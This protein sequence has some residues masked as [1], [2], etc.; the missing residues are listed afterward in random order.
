MKFIFVM[1][2]NPTPEQLAAASEGGREV[3]QLADKK[4]LA[5]PDDATLGRDWFSSRAEAIVATVSGIV[6]G[7]IL[8]VMGQAQLAAAVQAL[9][10][11][12]GAKLVESVTPRTSKDVQQ[13][14]GTVKKESVFSFS[15]FREVHRY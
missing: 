12:A 2:H 3:V 5:V 4:L 15:G 11:K 10:R 14:D 7:D 6:E 1:Q 8:H 13:P 9:A